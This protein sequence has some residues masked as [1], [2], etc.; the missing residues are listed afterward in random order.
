MNDLWEVC[1]VQA[2]IL[3]VLYL[4]F[5][6]IFQGWFVDLKFFFTEI[7]ER[8]HTGQEGIPENRAE[9]KKPP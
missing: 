5:C 7:F 3:K 4:L 6:I 2:N 8:G 9:I 1:F